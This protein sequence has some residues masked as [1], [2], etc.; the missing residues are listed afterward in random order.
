MIH[1]IKVVSVCASALMLLTG[2]SAEASPLPTTT[3][4]RQASTHNLTPLDT[5]P[6]MPSSLPGLVARRIQR[7]LASRLNVSMDSLTVTQ[8]QAESWTDTCLGR[9]ISE[10][11]CQER[12]VQ[13][14]VVRVEDANQRGWRYWSDR[15]GSRL[16]LVLNSQSDGRD[17]SADL[18]QSLLRSAAEQLQQPMSRLSIADIDLMTWEDGCLGLA[19][20][21]TICTQ[22]TVPGFRAVVKAGDREWIYHLSADGS[23]VVNN[24]IASDTAGTINAFLASEPDRMLLETAHSELSDSRIVFQ[25]RYDSFLEPQIITI[26][27]TADG[28]VSTVLRPIDNP[29]QAETVYTKQIPQSDVADFEALLEQQN[30]SHFDQVGYY[31]E[32]PVAFE[33]D[34]TLTGADATIAPYHDTI[35]ELPVALQPVIAM[36]ESIS[37]Y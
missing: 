9:P 22:A 13:G 1:S 21:D 26:T 7:D 28:L 33:G 6:P 18:S 10:N 29:E 35:D 11:V 19:A 20:P 4:T 24:A 30:F 3:S 36:W 27:L 15:T 5:P 37:G 32:R 25:S 34:Y 8:V 23:Q 16:R 31:T 2:L 17:F 14:W 12:A